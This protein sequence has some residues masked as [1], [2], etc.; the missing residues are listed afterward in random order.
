MTV[1]NSVAPMRPQ[2]KILPQAQ[3]FQQRMQPLANR[4]NIPS[5]FKP[6]TISPF[7]ANKSPQK[8]LNPA[9]N[10]QQSYVDPQSH[11]QT[12]NVESLVSPAILPD[13][14]RTIFKFPLFNR[15]QSE[16]FDV[17]YRSSSN[18]VVSGTY[19]FSPQPQPPPNP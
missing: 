3:M 5:P 6:S 2:P 12:F 4:T 18:L 14:F 10:R 13:R 1:Q 7:Q 19:H 15:M 16:C 11:T 8:S 17:A 9:Y